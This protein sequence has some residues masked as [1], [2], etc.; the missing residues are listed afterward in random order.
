MKYESN[1]N[2]V[3]TIKLIWTYHENG[4]H[5]DGLVQDCSNSIANALGLLQFFT[6]PASFFS[7]STCL[8]P[9]GQILLNS[10][11]EATCVSMYLAV[12]NYMRAEVKGFL[13]SR[14]LYL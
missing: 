2:A 8:A 3:H 12:Y 7:A 9:V 13:L 10:Y 4:D 14:R 6:K 1:N 5:L 11:E